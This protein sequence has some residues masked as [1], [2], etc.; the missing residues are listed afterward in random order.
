MPNSDLV[1]GVKINIYFI[2]H[3]PSHIHA[4]YNEDEELPETETF[5][6]YKGW[7]P[8]KQHRIALE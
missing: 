7:L 3:L 4:E 6:V 8:Q 5:E 1:N 2:E